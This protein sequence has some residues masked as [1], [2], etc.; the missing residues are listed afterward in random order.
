MGQPRALRFRQLLQTTT[1]VDPPFDSPSTDPQFTL[2]PI[3]PRGVGPISLLFMYTLPAGT[4]AVPPFVWTPWVRDPTTGF[5]GA[6]APSPALMDRQ[7]FRFEVDAAEVSLIPTD[8]G[9]TG[10][11]VMHVAEA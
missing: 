9:A 4:S 7:L 6:G 10:F 3:G 11:V 1:N 5:W 8:N 2:S